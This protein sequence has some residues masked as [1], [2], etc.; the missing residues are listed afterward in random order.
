MAGGVADVRPKNGV[1]CLPHPGAQRILSPI[2]LMVAERRRGNTDT[3]ED[4]DHRPAEGEVGRRRPL[5]FI[6][7]IQEQELAGGR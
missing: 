6:P 1:L 4:L 2:E 7:T 5:K 3:V